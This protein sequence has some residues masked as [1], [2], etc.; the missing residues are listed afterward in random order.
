GNFIFCTPGAEIARLERQITDAVGAEAIVRSRQE[1]AVI[2]ANNPYLGQ[3]GANLFLAR[4]P[5]DKTRSVFRDAFGPEGVPP[6]LSGDTVYFVWPTRFSGRK[7]VINFERELGVLGT[8]RT[9]R[10]IVRVLEMM[11]S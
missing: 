1:L 6:V 9:S 3:Q 11:N 4:E 2:V 5:I 8:M 10:V 7:S